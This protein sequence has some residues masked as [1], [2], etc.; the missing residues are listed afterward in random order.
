MY[1][2]VSASNV[3]VTVEGQRI[4]ETF[5][6]SLI[7]NVTVLP[8]VAATID[9]GSEPNVTVA[10]A[11]ALRSTN[12][13]ASPSNLVLEINSTTRGMNLT[14]TMDVVGVSERNGDILSFNM[15]WMPF[16]VNSDLRAQ[17]FGFNTV[18][19]T[20]FRS[21]VAYYANASRFVGRPNATI[22]GVTFFEN[23]TSVGPPAAENYVGNFTTL[24]FDSLN[25]DIDQWNR[26]YALSN[27]TTTWR[28]FPS[29]LLN[30]DM[31]VQRKNVTTDY[32]AT[33]GYN[34]TISVPGVGRARGRIILVEVGTGQTEWA[35]AALVILAVVSAIGVQVLFRNRKK[36]LAR[37]Q[38]K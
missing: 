35:M 25:P 21:V 34:A 36:K 30:F 7:Q 32:V 24:N 18:G 3:T 17:N 11:H 13:S 14:G 6:L 19:S 33:Y 1:A 22:T 12:S 2:P 31:R 23:S 26:T 27:N 37:F 10:F 28:Y 16:D 38:R 29:Q 15:T 5:A 20:Y 9:S 8:N 4:H